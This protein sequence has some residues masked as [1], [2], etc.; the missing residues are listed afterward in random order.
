MQA[1]RKILTTAL[2][3]ILMMVITQ[4]SVT[5]NGNSATLFIY[6]VPQY[7]VGDE[8][9]FHI[10]LTSIKGSPLDL[11]PIDIFLNE[12]FLETVETDASGSA[13]VQLQNRLRSG[14]YIIKAV[15][16][17]Y[18]FT[19]LAPISVEFVVAPVEVVIQS[20]PTIAGLELIFDGNLIVTGQDGMARVMVSEPGRYD[21]ELLPNT[22]L[23][24][25]QN[26]EFVQWFPTNFLFM[27]EV[28]VPGVTWQQV[29]FEKIY[30]ANFEFVDMN[31]F[32]VPATRIQKFILRGSNGNVIQL[33]EF[34]LSTLDVNNILARLSG[35][36]STNVVYSVQQVMVDGSDV[37]NQGQQRFEYSPGQAVRIELLLF[38]INVTSEDLIFGTPSGRGLYLTFP[39]LETRYY[40]F[41]SQNGITIRGL[42]R[43]DYS[44]RVEVD[45][46][47]T[48][49]I[50]LS[51][52]RDQEVRVPVISYIEVIIAAGLAI[53]I[54]VELPIWGH[55]RK[56][57]TILQQKRQRRE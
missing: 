33:S 14:T 31:G 24:D 36:D 12:T 7:E 39:N 56:I 54:G 34:E 37:V 15:Y 38:S 22:E 26:A 1:S 5:A 35:L 8:I 9:S 48:F 27:T 30:T 6:P 17:G 28:N 45:D 47:F 20:V 11:Q 44:I 19:V 55:R 29:G 23:L 18:Q 25:L 49:D 43:G 53:G 3:T 13:V 2:L 51:L 50:P 42:A 41:E 46:G 32:P 10:L 57:I 21:L 40:P 4:R 16:A 52:S